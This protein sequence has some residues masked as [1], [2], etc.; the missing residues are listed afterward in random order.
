MTRQEILEAVQR[1]ENTPEMITSLC[2]MLNEEL[3]KIA[4]V[5]AQKYHVR[6]GI[7]LNKESSEEPIWLV[8]KKSDRLWGFFIEKE[9]D[10][11]PVPITSASVATRIYA[12]KRLPDLEQ[13]LKAANTGMRDNL[14][15]ALKLLDGIASKG[16]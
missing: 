4:S 14:L 15:E 1:G 11:R 16:T 6:A 7:V 13:E 3:E 9:S 10:P 5:W 12:V 8:F 2:E